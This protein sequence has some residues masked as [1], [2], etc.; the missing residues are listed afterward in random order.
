M[1]HTIG[2]AARKNRAGLREN[3]KN[4]DDGTDIKRE[5]IAYERLFCARILGF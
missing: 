5:T 1:H 3:P 2:V 4:A